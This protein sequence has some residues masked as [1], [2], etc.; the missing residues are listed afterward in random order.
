MAQVSGHKNK[1]NL[2]IYIKSDQKVVTDELIKDHAAAERKLK[3]AEEV[4]ERNDRHYADTDKYANRQ[5][6]AVTLAEHD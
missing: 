1:N 3:S 6:F 5:Q 2:Q 4:K